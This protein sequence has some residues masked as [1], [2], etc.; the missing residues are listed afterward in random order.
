[1]KNEKRHRL[2]FWHRFYLPPPVTTAIFPARA[3]VRNGD[4]GVDAILQ[5]FA[6]AGELASRRE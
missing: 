2:L 5:G 6:V 1:V 3:S 4:N